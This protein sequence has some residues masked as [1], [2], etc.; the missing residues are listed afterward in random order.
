MDEIAGYKLGKL[1][2]EGAFGQT[3]EAVKDGQRVALKLIREEA[4][5]RDIDRRRFEREVRSLQKAVGPHVVKFIDAGVAQVG[6]ETRYFV[7]L[8]Y[9]EGWDL[10]KA[11]KDANNSFDEI[12]LKKI[13]TQTV[14]GL[15]VIHSHNIVHRDLKPANVFLTNEGKIKLLD[16]GLVK[17]LDYTTLTTLPGR[18]IGTPLYMSPE[19][20]Q[21]A[22]IDYRAD[23]YS[24]GVFIYHLVTNGNYPFHAQTPL[25]LFVKVVNNPPIS[26]TKYNRNISS[27]FENLILS[28]LS[29]QPYERVYNHDELVQAFQSVSIAIPRYV[30]RGQT[31][32][33]TVFP[34]RCFFRL[35]QTEKSVIQKFALANGSLDGVEFQ[36]SYL[37][38]SQNSLSELNRLNIPYLFDPVTYRLAYSTFAQAK[39][40]VEL[41]YVPDKNN[42]LIPDSLQTLEK[43]QTYARGCLDWQLQW[44]C[45]WLVAPFHYCRDLG[46]PWIDIDIK[47]L[48]ESLAY[49]KSLKNSLPIYAGLCLNIESYTV[50]ANRLA[51]LNRYSR[52]RADGYLFYF[53]SLDEKTNNPLQLRAALELMKLFQRLGKPVFACRAGTL[54]LGFL[55]AGIDGITNGIASLTGFSENNLLVNRMGG[56]EMTEKYYIPQMMLTLPVPLAEDILSDNRNSALRCDCVDCQKGTRNL[57]RVAKVHFLHVRTEEVREVNDLSDPKQRLQYFLDRV[58]TAFQ[59]CETIRKQQVVN[60]QPSYYTH[61]RTWLQAFNSE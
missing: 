24:L 27:E 13:F 20:L 31:A 52:A 39:G 21:G 4:I 49:A 35:L 59:T 15:Q 16:F 42:K 60:L 37:P 6:N 22:E 7:A 19:I 51:L 3:R 9:L 48:E 23:F 5:Q 34:K 11:F 54:G 57:K 8:E 18:P 53:D 43:L 46:S 58:N 56:Y 12:T 17:M 40:L 50:E 29:K 32:R 26:P 36:A 30:A 45:S 25:E 2:G 55:A 38:R 61:L 41:P 33:S 44:N 1:L 14:L 28:L 47:L 10:A